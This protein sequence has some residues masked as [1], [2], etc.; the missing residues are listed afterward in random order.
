[1]K[2]SKLGLLL[3][4]VRAGRFPS[5]RFDAYVHGDRSVGDGQADTLDGNAE[6]KPPNG[7]SA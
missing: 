2:A 4:K 3:K 7:Q 1:M 6:P 5:L